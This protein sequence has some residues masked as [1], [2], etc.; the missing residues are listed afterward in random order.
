M[1]K[2]Y[3]YTN[4]IGIEKEMHVKENADGEFEIDVWT[5]KYGIPCEMCGSGTMSKDKLITYIDHYKAVEIGSEQILEEGCCIS[6]KDLR[7]NLKT[8]HITDA[9]MNEHYTSI[10]RAITE[11]DLRKLRP[12]VPKT[13]WILYK[14]KKPIEGQWIFSC[15][16]TLNI[17]H[18][19]KI[20]QYYERQY[21]YWQFTKWMPIPDESEAYKEC[22][23]ES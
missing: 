18:R 10:T 5:V 16:S 22:E 13:P 20:I 15:Y 2:K 4:D 19:Y 1:I 7:D 6:L 9:L 17:E 11:L 14:E 8:L 3:R 12:V 23:E 21:L